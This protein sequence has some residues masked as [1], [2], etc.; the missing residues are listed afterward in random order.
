VIHHVKR[1]KSAD[2]MLKNAERATEQKET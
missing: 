1:E 2:E